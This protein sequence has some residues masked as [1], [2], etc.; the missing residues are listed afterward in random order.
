MPS[1]N[2][3]ARNTMAA[4]VG[5]LCTGTLRLLAG[6]TT[7]VDHTVGPYTAGA[8][9]VVSDSTITDATVAA[10]G[11]L[12]SAKIINGSNEV[13]LTVGIEGSGAEVIVAKRGASPAST[14]LDYVAGGTSSIVS[15]T[16]TYPAS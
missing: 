7:V 14:D 12:T 1:L 4:S 8:T 11:T 9:G 3:A 13:T 2:T 15:V 5:T 10:T 16:L 6:S